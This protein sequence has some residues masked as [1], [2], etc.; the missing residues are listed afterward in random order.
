[1]NARGRF[2]PRAVLALFLSGMIGQ[3]GAARADGGPDELAPPAE[4]ISPAPVVASQPGAGTSVN[5]APDPEEPRQTSEEKP[6]KSPS[7]K[8]AAAGNKVQEGKPSTDEN[9]D[10]SRLSEDPIPLEK[11]PVRPNPLIELGQHFL[12]TG[13]LPKGFTLPGGATWQPAFLTWGTLRSAI[14]D[15]EAGNNTRQAA[16]LNRAD[17]FGQL[18]L[19]PTERVIASFRPLDENGKFAGVTFSPRR[20]TENDHYNGVVRTLYFEGDFGEMFP[21]LDPSD[22]H[23]L[24]YGLAV[25]RMPLSFQE[26]MLINDAINAFGVVRNSLRPLASASNLRL[27]GLFSWGN[28]NRGGNDVLDKSARLF[29]LFSQFELSTSVA[30]IDFAYVDA[31]A[32]TGRGVY[33]GISS[34]Q[35]I[36]GWLNTTF[37]VLGSYAVHQQTTSVGSGVLL[38]SAIS[39]TPTGT[40]DIVYV[41]T[42]GAIH[43]Y[44]PAARDAGLGGP[45][46]NVGI[47]YESVGLGSG[48]GAVLPNQARD[49]FGAAIGY[50]KFFNHT[51]TQVIFELGGRKGTATPDKRSQGALAVRFQQAIGR[52]LIA[53]VEGFAHARESQSPRYGARYELFVKY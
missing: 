50:Q 47:L 44:T 43:N 5:L 41:D 8:P 14:H 22:S 1:M 19:T 21:D 51:R 2:I 27:T 12:G 36:W 40:D 49:S 30:D 11:L 42:Y 39:W 35:R 25:G 29:G 32:K 18:N 9:G 7:E 15:V 10:T 31:D 45:L 34:V 20:R 6:E 13:T 37:R 46:T 23:L 24:D 52:H 16:W 53:R 26:G 48:Y 4:K 17:I 28:V 33:G 3:A 38:Y